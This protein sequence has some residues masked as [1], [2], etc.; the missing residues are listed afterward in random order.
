MV[1]DSPGV[2][3]LWVRRLKPQTCLD[4]VLATAHKMDDSLWVE[5]SRLVDGLEEEVVEAPLGHRL[6]REEAKPIILAKYARHIEP[7]FPKDH[8]KKLVDL[9][10][11]PAALYKTPVDEYMDLCVKEKIL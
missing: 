6:R 8:V 1:L 2:L 5:A 4:A 10:N 11:D 9:G 3:V 7:H